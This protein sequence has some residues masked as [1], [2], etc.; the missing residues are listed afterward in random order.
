MFLIVGLCNPGD[1]YQMTRHNVGS[2]V[3]EHMAEKWGKKFKKG[4]GP[5]V[6]FE[7][8]VASKSVIFARPTTYMN[9]S[10]RAVADL[11]LRYGVKLS[12]LLLIVDDLNLPLGKLRLR[13]MGSDGGHK[14]LES[15]INWLNSDAFV[16]LRLGIDLNDIET[17]AS[18]Y[19]LSPFISTELPIVNDMIERGCKVVV[20]FV[21]RGIDWTMNHYN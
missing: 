15:I 10:G 2:M 3:L 18:E 9:N 17:D 14:G 19:V 20:D 5:Y 6:I 8:T 12:H 7:K 16:R 4:K 11:C 21:R 13:K 1:Q